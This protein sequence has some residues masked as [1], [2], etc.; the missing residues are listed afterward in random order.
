MP[1][2]DAMQITVS[3]EMENRI[4]DSN[5]TDAR[6]VREPQ[7]SFMPWVETVMPWIWMV[8]AGRAWRQPKRKGGLSRE[9]PALV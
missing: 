2:T 8:A 6:S 4:D 7:L 1:I 3:N 5:S 9:R